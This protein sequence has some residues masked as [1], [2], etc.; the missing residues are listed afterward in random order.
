M[1]AIKKE[2]LIYTIEELDESAQEAAYMEWPQSGYDY[3]WLG[4]S[5]GSIKHFLS[6]FGLDIKNYSLGTYERS[7]IE[8]GEL[9]NDNTRGINKKAL[10][11]MPLSDG[12]YI[13]ETLREKLLETFEKTGD[14][15]YAIKSAIDEAVSDIISDME[16]NESL[17][18]F[19][20]TATANEWTFLESG[21]FYFE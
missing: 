11:D 10:H 1:K 16:Y 9:S 2:F 13:G 3:F 17:E 20:E 21:E 18:A 14:L 4:E 5:L 19:I 12:Y 6:F 15:K 7:Y 8:I